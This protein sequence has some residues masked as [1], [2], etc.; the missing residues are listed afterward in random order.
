MTAN[1][2]AALLAGVKRFPRP[3]EN[4]VDYDEVLAAL[5]AA[6]T[7]DLAEA[8]EIAEQLL[9][10]ADGFSVRASDTITALLARLAAQE[11][12]I[13][14]LEKDR[15]EYRTEA[16]KHRD[17]ALEWFNKNHASQTALA[18]ERTKTAK[19]VEALG[20]MIAVAEQDEWDKAMT[21]RQI[22]FAKARAA[23]TEAGQ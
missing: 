19:L 2:F 10:E 22:I 1:P 6:V 4:V 23:I 15:D 8:G 14:G 12:Q 7:A 20:D 5:A 9:R 16:Q 11:A 3:Y 13:K 21:G 18:A 17:D